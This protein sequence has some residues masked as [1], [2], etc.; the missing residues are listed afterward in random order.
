MPSTPSPG[1]P[2]VNLQADE[3]KTAQPPFLYVQEQGPLPVADKPGYWPFDFNPQRRKEYGSDG[4]PAG[5][6]DEYPA[7]PVIAWHIWTYR[8][9]SQSI[10]TPRALLDQQLGKQQSPI[11][12]P[13]MITQSPTDWDD[14]LTIL[15]TEQPNS[16][17]EAQRIA[18]AQSFAGYNPAIVQ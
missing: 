18:L 9:P 5:S 6:R 16:S 11:I 12:F 13:N 17:A 7:N 15:P 3:R 4:L 10:I 2:F 14:D 8:D 1:D